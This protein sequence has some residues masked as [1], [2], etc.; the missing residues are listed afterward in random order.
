M[1]KKKKKSYYSRLKLSKEYL[2][3]DLN[4]HRMFKAF[5]EKY[6]NVNICE[7][8]YRRVFKKDFPKLSFKTPRTDTC[9]ICDKMKLQIK[10]ASG[11]PNFH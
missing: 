9:R 8:Y 2:S 6:T 7:R 10:S 5:K 4:I 1:C 3:P 11:V